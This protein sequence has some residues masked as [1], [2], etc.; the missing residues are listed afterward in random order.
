MADTFAPWLRRRPQALQAPRP[1][2]QAWGIRPEGIT[3][4][5]AG[6]LQ[7]GRFQT[8]HRASGPCPRS[9]VGRLL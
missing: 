7:A 1:I 3:D 6:R 9:S 8:A 4:L 5:E 2:A